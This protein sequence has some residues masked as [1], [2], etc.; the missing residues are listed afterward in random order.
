MRDRIADS[1]G[2]LLGASFVLVGAYC[3][4]NY[5][6]VPLLGAPQAHLGEVIAL[7]WLVYALLWGPVAALKYHGAEARRVERALAHGRI[8]AELKAT[9]EAMIE[10]RRVW[11]R[12][13]ER[14]EG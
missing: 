4:W 10:L 13:P 9:R 6:A 3:G 14:G 2:W 1:I 5:G 12:A 8:E 11:D 7:G